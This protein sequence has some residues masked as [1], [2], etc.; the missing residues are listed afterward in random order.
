MDG[1]GCAILLMLPRYIHA[2]YKII[3][4][5]HCII[6]IFVTFIATP[7]DGIKLKPQKCHFDI[8]PIMALAVPSMMT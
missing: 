2:L 6:V 4:F 8:L 5:G 3:N 1:P 7:D